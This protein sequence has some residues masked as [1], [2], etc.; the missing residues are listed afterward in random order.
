MAKIWLSVKKLMFPYVREAATSAVAWKNLE[1]IYENKGLGRRLLI[2]LFHIKL[3]NSESM[4]EY[5]L[6]IMIVAPS[7]SC[8]ET[9]R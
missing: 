8:K 5:I 2:Q 6:S 3:S 7:N 4:N 9:S 1:K